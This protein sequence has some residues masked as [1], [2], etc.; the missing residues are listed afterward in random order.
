MSKISVLVVEDE[1]IVNKDIQ[2]SLKKFDY[3]I[4]GACSRGQDA[5]EL[6][7]QNQPDVV[8]MD[9]MLKGDK[10]GIETAKMIKEE[11]DIPVIFLTAHADESTLNNAKNSDPYGYVLKPFKEI[12]LKSSIEMALN[13]HRLVKEIIQE[14]DRLYTLHEQNDTHENSVIFVKNQGRLVRVEFKDVYFVEALK[15]YVVINTANTRYTVHSTM[16]DIG[17]RL[18]SK[19]FVRVHRSFIVRAD[20][21]IAIENHHVILENDKKIIPIG[22]LYKSQ[23]QKKLNVF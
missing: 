6:A 19:D 16:K 3:S 14:R 20:K 4:A 8:L 1:N 9:I 2:N 5:I 23:V 17:K 13:K 15:D 11:L 18:N 22:G 12:E 10:N 21:I 7:R